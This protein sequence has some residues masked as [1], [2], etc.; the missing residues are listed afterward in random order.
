MTTHSFSNLNLR[1]PVPRR[2][3]EQVGTDEQA[4]GGDGGGNFGHEKS[5]RW[6][7]ASLERSP[8]KV[9]S[10]FRINGATQQKIQS[11]YVLIPIKTYPL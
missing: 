11:G 2:R 4:D 5:S 3:H 6:D 1:W 9:C 7:A 8:I 10:T